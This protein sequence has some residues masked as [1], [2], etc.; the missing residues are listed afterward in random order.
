MPG[1]SLDYTRI[2]SPPGVPDHLQHHDNKIDAALPGK[3]GLARF[4]EFPLQA[5]DRL[6]TRAGGFST[7]ATATRASTGAMRR[8]NRLMSRLDSPAELAGVLRSLRLIK[9]PEP[10]H[11][12]ADAGSA[13]SAGG[14]SGPPL[15]V[16]SWAVDHAAKQK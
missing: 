3:I 16:G 12:C 8:G 14:G 5:F 7:A 11:P 9:Y 2:G 6:V 1:A 4:L 10:L 13:G 15:P